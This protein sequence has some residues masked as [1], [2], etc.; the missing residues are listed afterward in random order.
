M[1]HTAADF[2]D[3]RTPENDANRE[4]YCKRFCKHHRKHKCAKYKCRI[5]NAPCDPIAEYMKQEYKK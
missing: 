5:I 1:S 2:M 3:G 4:R